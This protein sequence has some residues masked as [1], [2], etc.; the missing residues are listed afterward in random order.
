MEWRDR[1]A[2]RFGYLFFG[3]PNQRST[4]APAR[5]FYLYFIQPY[6]PPRYRDEKQADEVFFQLTKVDNAFRENLDKYAAAL[7]LASTASGQAKKEYEKKAVGYLRNLVNWLQEHMTTAI[8]VT[9]QGTTKPLLEWIKGKGAATG[10]RANVRDIVNAVGSSCLAAYFADQAPEYPAFSVLVTGANRAQAAQDA[11]RW[12]R[13]TTKTQQAIAVLDALELLDGDRLDAHRSKHAN[14]ILSLL[15]QKGHGQILNRGELIQNV[16]GVEYMAPNQYRLEPEWVV[17]LAAAL[18]YNGDVVLAIPGKKFDANS[19][20]SLVTTPVD[21]LINFKHIE[22]PKEWNLPALKALFELLGLTPGMA[23]LVTQGKHEPI[24]ELQKA[25]NQTVEKLVVTRQK[26]QGLTFWGRSL[27]SEQQQTEY[28]DRL[29]RTK[30]FLESLQ[31]YS[32]P[33]K[34]KNFRY[35]EQEV[36]GYRTGLQTLQEIEALQE[37]VT[38]LGSVASYLST[39]E[40][41]LPPSVTCANQGRARENSS[42][43]NQEGG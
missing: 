11:L 29:D 34:L 18:V 8:D 26:L 2:T 38:N 6:D 24:Q 14:H 20:D 35:Q 16:L 25:V 41:V 43:Y 32:T 10:V 37:L 12:L 3:A 36:N 22:Q 27:L 21:E 23:Q 17:V 4:A 31:A 39:A 42:S 13:G 15:R 7:D 40:A 28:W 19:L 1:K 30:T 5:D 33:G 9:H